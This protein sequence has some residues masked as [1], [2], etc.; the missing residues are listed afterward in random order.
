MDHHTA[1]MRQEES[2]QFFCISAELRNPATSDERI[3]ELLP[4]LEAIQMHTPSA[5]LRA[6]CTELLRLFDLAAIAGGQRA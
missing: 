4:E 1:A 3:L 5:Y 2:R 6:R